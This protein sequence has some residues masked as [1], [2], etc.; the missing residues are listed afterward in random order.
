MVYQEGNGSKSSVIKITQKHLHLKDK[1]SNFNHIYSKYEKK[2][3]F[4]TNGIGH[5]SNLFFAVDDLL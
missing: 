5:Y 3:L 2:W 4:I 1:C